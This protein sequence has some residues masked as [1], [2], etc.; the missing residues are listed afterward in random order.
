MGVS[1]FGP[2][3]LRALPLSVL[4][5]SIVAGCAGRRAEVRGQA[6]S[7]APMPVVRL[8]SAPANGTVTVHGTMVEKCPAAGCWFILQDG[9]GRVKV[10]LKAAGFVVTDVPTGG[11]TTVTGRL[12]R[13]D[14]ETVV[15]A[16]GVRFQ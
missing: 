5:L 1:L 3:F 11:E 4:L 15:E 12:K 2:P 6:P 10:D 8:A 14:E 13:H 16:A 7:G 9:T